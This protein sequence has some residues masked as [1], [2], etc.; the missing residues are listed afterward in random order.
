MLETKKL[1]I[2]TTTVLLFSTAVICIIGSTAGPGWSNW[3]FTT[4]PGQS[5]L[6]SV[7]LLFL[8]EAAVFGITGLVKSLI[9]DRVRWT[10]AEIIAASII[11]ISIILVYFTR[12]TRVQ[13]HPLKS[14]YFVPHIFTC[15]LSYMFFGCG[16]FYSVK[17]LI[18]K[19]FEYE[20]RAYRFICLG[21]PFLSAGIA[22]GS[23][24]AASAWGA[25]WSW[26]PKESFSLA[27]WLVLAGYLHFKIF[28]GQRFLRLNSFLVIIGFMLIIIGVT[29]VNFSRVFAGLHN[30]AG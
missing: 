8:S 25:W 24:W 2:L 21:F 23:I 15:L 10:R 22:L 9:R 27:L 1:C 3:F 4:I 16:A 6:F 17:S 5:L 14:V 20:K 13:A 7:I 28:F 18:A 12:I 19:S 30:Y 11:L 26:D 29:L